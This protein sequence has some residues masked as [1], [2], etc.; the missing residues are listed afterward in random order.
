MLHPYQWIIFYFCL[1][2]I[3]MNFIS[4]KTALI[5]CILKQMMDLTWPVLLSKPRIQHFLRSDRPSIPFGPLGFHLQKISPSFGNQHF[6]TV[7]LR[8]SVRLRC[9]TRFKRR[10]TACSCVFKVITLVWP[11]NA[12]YFQTQLHALNARWKQLLQF[13]WTDIFISYNSGSQL[14]GR[15]TKNGGASGCWYSQYGL[16]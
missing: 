11:T 1:Y 5:F 3:K 2:A 8:L 14:G 16:F 10:F 12:I 7:L 9:D 15:D 6:A 13:K 4:L